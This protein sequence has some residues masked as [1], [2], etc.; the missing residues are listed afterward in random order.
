M[1]PRLE[2]SYR[3]VEYS[4][5]RNQVIIGIDTAVVEAEIDVSIAIM[6]ATTALIDTEPP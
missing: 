4:I 2:N 1:L 3:V 5:Y 6:A